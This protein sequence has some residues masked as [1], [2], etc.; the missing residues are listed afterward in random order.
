MV[1]CSAQPEGGEGREG[2]GG[3]GGEG[4]GGEGKRGREGEREGRVKRTNTALF[5]NDSWS[6][7]GQP[8]PH[9]E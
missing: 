7:R 2:R 5:T 6:R 4:R 3:R 8:D 1:S 9:C